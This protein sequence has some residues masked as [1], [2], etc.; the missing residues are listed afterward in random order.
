MGGFAVQKHGS[1]ASRAAGNGNLRPI[2]RL[3]P[4]EDSDICLVDES[5][6]AYTQ[7]DDLDGRIA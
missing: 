6:Q 2:G 4:F 7:V 3:Q 1:S 5:G